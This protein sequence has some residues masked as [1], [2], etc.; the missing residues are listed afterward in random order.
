VLNGTVILREGDPIDVDGNGSFDDD[1]FVGRGVNTNAAFAANDLFVDENGVVWAIV[2]LRTAAGVDINDAA[3]GTPDAFVRID[4]TPAISSLCFGD[5]TT[6][7]PCPCAN[8][9]AAGKGCDNSASTGG[10]LL[11]ASGS[12]SPDAVVLSAS[13]ML[14]TVTHIYLQGNQVL[15]AGTVFG[16]GVRCV[17]GQLLRLAV[18]TASG[19][20]SQFPAGGDPSITARSAALGDPIAPGSSRW[21]QTYYRDPNLA[22][23]PAPPG[24]SWNVTNGVRV[25]WQ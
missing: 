9:G 4:P 20:A 6:A 7:T 2:Q 11:T 18:K 24:D 22:F 5:G 1:A 3:F 21:Y 17:G 25:V 13:D 12:T 23:C 19:G 16:D 15:P 14:P 10:A 8:T